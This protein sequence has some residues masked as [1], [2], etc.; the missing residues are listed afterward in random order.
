MKGIGYKKLE[1]KNK[2]NEKGERVER[3]KRNFQKRRER[4]NRGREIIIGKKNCWRKV[5]KKLNEK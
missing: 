1:G 2:I 3:G 4:T 5:R